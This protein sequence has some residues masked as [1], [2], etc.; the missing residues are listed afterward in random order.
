MGFEKLLRQLIN[1]E[2]ARKNYS[3]LESPQGLLVE[4]DKRAKYQRIIDT[5]EGSEADVETVSMMSGQNPMVRK[6]SPAENAERKAALEKSLKRRGL[7]FIRIGAHFGGLPEKSV[8]VLNPTMLEMDELCREY[9]QW[10][11]VWG[12]KYMIRPGEHIMGFGMYAIDHDREIGWQRDPGS[13]ETAILMKA[14][15]LEGAEDDYSLDPTSGKRF[16]LSFYDE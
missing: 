5:L 4:R 6:V 14:S 12:Q 3:L 2:K 8:L 13:K 11:F 15:E 9:D 10:G 7:R 1:E 16:G